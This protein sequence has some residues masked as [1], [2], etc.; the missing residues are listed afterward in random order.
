MFMKL[1]IYKN[2]ELV[3]TIETENET[4]IYKTLC[5]CLY[6]KETKRASKTSIDYDY[7]NNTMKLTQ[8]FDTTK[9]QLKNTTY[10]YKYIFE[11]IR[12]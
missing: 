7:L 3:N 10:T 1:E 5:Q 4:E 6:A 2:R 9:T 12:L 11:D 8:H